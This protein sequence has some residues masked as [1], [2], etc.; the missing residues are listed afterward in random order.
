MRFLTKI[1]T[2]LIFLT[3]MGIS[4]IYA[5]KNFAYS[6]KEPN[7]EQ[8]MHTKLQNGYLDREISKAIKEKRFKD[9]KIYTNL[10]DRFGIELKPATKELIKE[11]FTTTKKITRG[12]KNFVKGFL[13]GKANSGTEVAGAVASDFTIYGDLRDIRREGEKYIADEP[14]DKMIL[15]LSMAG[16]A[17]SATQLVT[18][19][20]SS[21]LKAAASSLKIAKREKVLTKGF[22][23]TI[24]KD[25]EKAV[26]IESLKHLKLGSIKELKADAKIIKNSVN[27]KPLKPL[28][29]NVHTIAKNTSIADSIA[30][31]KYIDNTKDLKS[32]AKLSKR[33][34]GATRG[35]FKLMSK[36]AFRLVKV[37][38][39]W[40][41][42][43]IIG[44]A[45]FIFSAFGFLVTLFRVFR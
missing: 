8:I 44:V 39:K 11:E 27:T 32:V 15:G 9:I 14:Y 20:G 19:G 21:T 3:L 12:V 28:L 17:L 10:A 23:K 33:Y 41:K 35:I 13:S 34:K 31:L 4:Y 37:G 43:L 24:S 25:L 36:N 40:S 7:I 6:Y 30:L 42:N 18:F 38:V 16:L 2:L 1:L 5:K 26:D 22:S 45:G 29:T